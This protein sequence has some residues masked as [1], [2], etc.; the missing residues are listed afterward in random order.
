MKT[1]INSNYNKKVL[2]S[3]NSLSDVNTLTENEMML[4]TKQK[5]N[6]SITKVVPQKIITKIN[7]ETKSYK[8]GGTKI[9]KNVGTSLVTSFRNKDVYPIYIHSINKLAGITKSVE[10]N[11][12]LSIYYDGSYEINIKNLLKK[13][14]NR[15]YLLFYIPDLDS[16]RLSLSLYI[17]ENDK[18][19]ILSTIL[20]YQQSDDYNIKYLGHRYA[21]FEID[22]T[23]KKNIIVKK[24]SNRDIAANDCFTLDGTYYFYSPQ[25]HQ[26]LTLDTR[27]I[28]TNSFHL[29]EGLVDLDSIYGRG[30]KSPKLYIPIRRLRKANHCLRYLK[31]NITI[32][33]FEDS[34]DWKIEAASLIEDKINYRNPSIRGFD[35]SIESLVSISFRE[36]MLSL[37]N[38]KVYELY[39]YESIK[40]RLYP[41]S[42]SKNYHL[43]MEK[44]I[45]MISAKFVNEN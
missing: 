35:G 2:V 41:D 26:Y 33:H 30:L 23:D 18:D 24:A 15:F 16:V 27:F 36:K 9:I 17:K 34:E 39:Y 37:D 28:K 8:V 12:F 19:I 44:N 45:K 13:K 21:L 4:Y 38:S 31:C 25:K 40:F 14:I 42:D 1:R 11:D 20:H 5:D 29:F 32:P 10:L 3:G 22:I 6:E 7:G 43:S